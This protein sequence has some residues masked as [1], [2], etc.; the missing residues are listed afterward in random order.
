MSEPFI[1]DQCFV[2]KRVPCNDKDAYIVLFGKQIGKQV[3]LAKG[4]GKNSSKLSALLEIGNLLE[5]ELLTG[6]A[7]IKLI[8]CQQIEGYTFRFS[9]YEAL[10]TSVYLCELVDDG[11]EKADNDKAVY[12]LLDKSL[13]SMQDDNI[14]EI[15]LL[16]EC[17][18]LNILGYGAYTPDNISECLRVLPKA[19]EQLTAL[20]EIIMF[21]S[22]TAGNEGMIEN[23][24][25]SKEARSLLRRMTRLDL[26][27]RAEL[28][29]ASAKILDDATRKFYS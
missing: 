19:S 1:K 22:I 2:L 7:G 9:S 27:R 17:K 3:A 4:V 15:R 24:R 11:M 6:N 29:I 23:C 28:K 8:S 25:L 21:I 10:L 16:F 12:E 5:V 18:F 26:Q 13:A 14:A 20:D